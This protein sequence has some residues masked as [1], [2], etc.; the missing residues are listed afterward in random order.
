MLYVKD[1]IKFK[2]VNLSHCCS[3]MNVELCGIEMTDYNL[4]ILLLYRPPN[5]DF[6]LFLDSI[7]KCLSLLNKQN[8]DIVLG[9]DFNVA[10]NMPSAHTESL[11]AVLGGQGFT[12][13]VVC[14]PEGIAVS[15]PLPQIL[16]FGIIEWRCHQHLLP[17]ICQC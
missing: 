17:I 11:E 1:G 2:P 7:D 14:P 10:L 5:G 15:T 13:Q 4:I 6:E 16:M 9:G 12:S 3:E 8:K